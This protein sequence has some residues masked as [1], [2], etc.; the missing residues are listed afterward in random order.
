MEYVI[1]TEQPFEEVE[2]RMVE[3]LQQQGWVVHRT[4]S[5]RSAVGA[6][7]SGERTLSAQQDGAA[8]EAGP[9]YSV[10][11]LYASGAQRRSLGLLTLYQLQRR[12]VITFVP[13]LPDG[14]GTEMD[15][16]SVPTTQPAANMDAELVVALA[17]SGL[18]FCVGV[19]KEND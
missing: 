9:G 17:L 1:T 3:A 11:M 4:F 14:E 10:L 18:D 16:L 15:A 2:S 12:T 7:R 5:L 13:H 6:A 8:T 19:D